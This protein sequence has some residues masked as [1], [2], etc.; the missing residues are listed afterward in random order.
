[1]LGVAPFTVPLIGARLH[2]PDRLA[3]PTRWSRDVGKVRRKVGGIE[4][5]APPARLF[6]MAGV[7]GQ[8]ISLMT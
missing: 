8:S 3:P 1:M 6:E 5:A 2:S 4:R 7:D